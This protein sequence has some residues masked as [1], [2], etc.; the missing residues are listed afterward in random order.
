MVSNTPIP[1]QRSVQP[2]P[3]CS[4]SE[5]LN[6][7]DTIGAIVRDLQRLTDDAN[8]LDRIR[9]QLGKVVQFGRLDVYA[10]E[11]D[12][13]RLVD[14][15]ESVVPVVGSSFERAIRYREPCTWM[16]LPYPTLC[17]DE[18][19]VAE[20]MKS[21][22]C[23][24][25]LA[26]G[27]VV[28][29]VVIYSCTPY[30]FGYANENIL[31][32]AD[33]VGQFLLQRRLRS[34]ELLLHETRSELAARAKLAA[35]GQLANGVAHEVNNPSS[36]VLLN[37]E[38]MM[39]E[40]VRQ[41]EPLERAGFAELCSSFGEVI[42]ECMD[43]IRRIRTIVV[44]LQTFSHSTGEMNRV[45][46]DAIVTSTLEMLGPDSGARAG[47]IELNLG[48]VPE[49]GS[50][51][52]RLGQVVINLVRNAL[53]SLA[54]PVARVWVST[55]AEEG[56]A[57]L[58][59]RDEGVGI[60]EALQARIFEP[61]FT[62]KPVGSGTGLGLATAREIVRKLGGSVRFTSREGQ[63]TTFT[64]KLPMRPAAASVRPL[65]WHAE[66]GEPRKVR[67]LFIE[68][69]EVL[70]RTL[71]RALSGTFDVVAA[72]SAEVAIEMLAQ[73][74]DV[75]VIVS[76]LLLPGMSGMKF[77]DHIAKKH[78][79]LVRCTLFLTG[80]A[81]TLEARKFVEM[82]AD[83]VLNKPL[84]AQALR[85]VLSAIGGGAASS[86]ATQELREQS[87]RVSG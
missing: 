25:L 5:V 2:G 41:Q 66:R 54:S 30:A 74:A 4:T 37:L 70:R 24:P 53:Q 23:L 61:F 47:T 43:G 18:G 85:S 83:I 57:V 50:N 55:R 71:V 52:D 27:D 44:E 48:G 59:V 35:V 33:I 7:H 84:E 75:D 60:P 20:G 78:P 26:H 34:M 8:V 46:L 51:P 80:G 77:F 21:S 40:L 56:C 32:V 87:P 14:P 22:I 69:E 68:D 86:E 49:F 72:K 65:T 45:S 62:T 36:Y 31:A 19:A 39:E 15:A 13:L 64:V 16:T 63:G 67:V 73:D 76:D 3:D 42:S 17:G 79:E 38:F 11:G 6:S 10:K 81:T 58:E 1:R 82:H 28:G 9:S 12:S 29:A